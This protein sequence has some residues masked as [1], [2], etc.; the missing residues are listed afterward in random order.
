MNQQWTDIQ[1]IQVSEA[2][3]RLGNRR[4]NNLV[5]GQVC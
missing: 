5:W 1:Y 2:G 4:G 3:C